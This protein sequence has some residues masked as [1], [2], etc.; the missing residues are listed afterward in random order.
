MIT[1]RAIHVV[2]VFGFLAFVACHRTGR[3]EPEKGTQAKRTEIRGTLKEGA[4]QMVILD[5]M[6]AR[7]YIP[8][9]TVICD[10]K[11]TF[12]LELE[13]IQTAFYALRI[14]QE[15]Y[16]TL[17]V[18]PGESLLL[19]GIYGAP[20]QYMVEGSEGSELLMVLSRKHKE[21]L[22]A[23]GAIGRKN[24]E[25]RASPDFADLKAELDR[26]FDSI[27]TAF[28][29]YSLDFIHAN[30]ESLAILIALYNLYGQGLPVF[31]PET[32][33]QAYRFVD[34][35]LYS[36]YSG[37]EIVELLHSQ[38]SEAELSGLRERKL[39]GLEPGQNAPDFVSYGPDGEEIALSDF[40][41][42]YVLVAFWAGWSKLSM[43][44]N[45]YL[46]EAWNKYRT[47]PFRILQVSLDGDRDVWLNAIEQEDLEWNQV[48]DLRRWE[49]V[50]A[51]I[52]RVERIPANYL[53]D[54]GG[55]IIARDLF[56]ESLMKRLDILFSK[57]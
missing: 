31:H 44:E 2:F 56:G 51:D 30:R 54:P 47:F 21:A 10:D 8:I 35:V 42:T 52:Y 37:I 22:E 26:Q 23:L 19:K 7:E 1:E 32:D 12:R 9:D 34:S 27:S 14:G 4:G 11:G 18:E 16:I 40:E 36:R 13:S 39:P 24:M 46:K 57:E 17:L 48:S 25:L 53:I 15:G 5:E 45:R 3:S 38:V 55:R 20:D 50:V 41:G 29:D 33:I 49:T 28:H 43:V 6:A